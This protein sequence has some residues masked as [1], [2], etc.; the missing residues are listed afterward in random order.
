M[1][2]TLSVVEQLS[3]AT[4]RIKAID[5]KSG[6]FGTGFIMSF[7][8]D[9]KA[10]VPVLITNGHVLD[11]A[12]IV[13]LCFTTADAQGN[14]IGKWAVGKAV[15]ECYCKYHPL[16]RSQGDGDLCALAIAPFINDVISSGHKPMY[17]SIGMEM[18]ATDADYA[19]LMQLDEVAMVGYPNALIDS[20]NNQPIF[21]RGVLATSPSLDYDGN[22]EFLTDMATIGGSSG[23]PVLQISNG[24]SVNQRYGNIRIG[25]GATCKLLGVHRGGF[26]YDAEG[27]LKKLSIPEADA[28]VSSTRIPINLGIVIKA[29]RIRELKD[30]FMKG[31]NLGVG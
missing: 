9:D 25:G 28:I 26:R 6:W 4:I 14:P 18:L 30:T 8:R 27:R 5:D 1:A 20:V 13:S 19:E 22:K 11:N 7:S 2:N 12:K 10:R 23:S 17:K 3:Y 24:V 15:A 29:S 21:R 16:F 31:I